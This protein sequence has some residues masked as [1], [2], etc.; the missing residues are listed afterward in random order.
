VT[1]DVEPDVTPDVP[2]D[3]ACP[4]VFGT[5][6]VNS[7]NGD[8]SGLTDQDPQEIRGALCALQFISANDGGTVAVNGTADLQSNGTFT[9]T[10]LT[11]NTMAR[12]PCT[13]LWDQLN[14]RMTVTCNQGDANECEVVLRR[15]GPRP[16]R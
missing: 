8:C 11:L 2:T 3:A 1:P 15:T 14:E 10:T 9:S 6:E 16:S 13:G 5:Y 4:N 12:T 7:E